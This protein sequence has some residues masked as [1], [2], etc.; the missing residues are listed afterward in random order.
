MWWD[1]EWAVAAACTGVNT[2]VVYGTDAGNE[3]VTIEQSAARFEPGATFATEPPD[4]NEI[5]WVINLGEDQVFPFGEDNDTLIINDWNAAG[6]VT[7]GEDTGGIR[8]R[9]PSGDRSQSRPS[10]T[11]H[12]AALP[13]RAR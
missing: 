4:L 3:T 6:A 11:D 1:D 10:N 13:G 5:E 7:I 8:L 9:H 12:S 2:I